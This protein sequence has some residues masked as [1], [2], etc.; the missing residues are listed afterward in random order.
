[1]TFSLHFLGAK[2]LDVDIATLRQD[3]VPGLTYTMGGTST[4]M[5]DLDE[6]TEIVFTADSAGGHGLMNNLDLLRD[7]L[8][9]TNEA[10]TGGGSCPLEIYGLIEAAVGPDMSRLDYSTH[11]NPAIR[12]YDDYVGLASRGCSRRPA[13]STT[14]CAPRRTPTRPPS[15][16]T[17]ERRSR[18][19][20]CS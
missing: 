7:S 8:R 2:I 3:G 19:S 17:A 4:P 1:M 13:P 15:P 14:R 5:P 16:R 6:A 9:K 10:C 12:S 11:E 20:R 18:C